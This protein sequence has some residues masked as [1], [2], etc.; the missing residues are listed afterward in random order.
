MIMTYKDFVFK[1]LCQ[2]ALVTCT[3]K[4]CITVALLCHWDQGHYF[5]PPEHLLHMLL[6]PISKS[7]NVLAITILTV[8]K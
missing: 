8:Q 2:S 6:L 1:V 5:S 7:F 4:A 3:K